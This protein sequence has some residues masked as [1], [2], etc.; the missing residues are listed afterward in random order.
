MAF[1]QRV[2]VEAG[3]FPPLQSQKQIQSYVCPIKQCALRVIVITIFMIHQVYPAYIFWY[4]IFYLVSGLPVDE[5]RLKIW[6][7]VI[8]N[9]SNIFVLETWNEFISNS[10]FSPVSD[11][12]I[13]TVLISMYTYIHVGTDTQ[14]LTQVHDHKYHAHT[15]SV[16]S[17]ELGNKH[18]HSHTFATRLKRL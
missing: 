18:T 6:G 2:S 4:C 8:P 16:S 12:L 11:Q 14:G 7:F 10:C 1:I 13:Y 9:N 3:P 15:H 5:L 17:H